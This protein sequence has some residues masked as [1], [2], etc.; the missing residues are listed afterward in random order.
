MIKRLV[1]ELSLLVMI[2]ASQN[3][4]AQI[5]SR[6][7]TM[8]LTTIGSGM[9]GLDQGP[10]TSTEY[11]RKNSMKISSVVGNDAII[12]FDAEKITTI[13]NKSKTY[14]EMTFKQLQ[15]LVSRLGSEMG[16]KSQVEQMRKMM[17][18][19]NSTITLTKEGAGESIAGY[20]TEKYLLT[21]PVEMEIWAAPS[22]TVI[23]GVYYDLMK[24]QTPLNPMFD[25]KQIYEE[26]K[27]VNGIALKTVMTVRMMNMEMKATKVV[28]SIDNGAI[29]ASV[30]DVP[31]GYQ[32]VQ[33]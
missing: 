32:L 26:M 6:D 28:N 18:Q 14:S 12:R 31:A 27:K 19:V 21:G 29:A 9:P 4:N 15:E 7:L 24:I 25:M 17:G 1:S 11:Y 30:F 33:K 22:L 23:P 20:P 5:F 10:F 13:N 8:H 3:A 16:P 2:C